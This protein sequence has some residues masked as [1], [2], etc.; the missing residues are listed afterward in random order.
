MIIDDTSVL[1]GSANINDRSLLGHRDSEIGIFIVDNKSVNT[2]M[3]G[4]VFKARQFAHRMRL[5]LYQELFDLP[6]EDLVDPLDR[7]LLAKID[8]QVRQNTEIYR[9]CFGAIPDDNIR[10]VRDIETLRE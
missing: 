10:T 1:I 9:E 7:D 4:R 2:R 8:R 3:N 6:L 5:Q